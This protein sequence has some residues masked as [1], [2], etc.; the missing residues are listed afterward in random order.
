[1]FSAIYES[2]GGITIMCTWTSNTINSIYTK[3]TKCNNCVVK[4]IV[5]GRLLQ[6]KTSGMKNLSEEITIDFANLTIEKGINKLNNVKGIFGFNGS[7]KTA[8]M[9]SVD[10]Y[11]RIATDPTFLVQKD[12]TKKLDQL[13]N[14]ETRRFSFSIVFEFQKDTVLKHSIE[15]AKNQLSGNFYIQKENIAFS[16][17][18]TLNDS[19][20]SL[21]KKEVDSIA[22]LSYEEIVK[23]SLSFLK[24]TDLTYSSILP[25]V[26]EKMIE[27][28]E[29]NGKHPHTFAEKVF[30]NLFFSVKN[31][32]VYLSAS[33]EHNGFL[34]DKDALKSLLSDLESQ[35]EQRD[36]WADLY[37]TETIIP[38]N[39]YDAYVEN[40]RKLEK[41][42]RLFKPELQEIE[43]ERSEDKDAYHVKRLFKYE[44]YKVEY[45]FESSGIKQLVKLFT[46]LSRCANGGVVFIDEIDVNINAV[47]FEKLISFFRKYGEGQ[48]IFTTHNT[49]AM[50]ALKGQSRSI[51]VLGDENK[52]DVW[53]GKGNKSP[54]NDYFGGLFPHSPMNIE[55]FDFVNIFLGEE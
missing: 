30:S 33:D 55:D 34:F 20:K 11:L 50:N 41:F 32:D 22:V 51:L 36:D 53:V 37:S 15:L 31:M 9:T 40:N 27:R 49:E 28:G 52:M 5:M 3:N 44:K 42:V 43:L 2:E 26:I 4:G 7:G 16:C 29:R 18:R 13:L 14:F 38:K 10:Y 54:I 25:K 35:K 39:M 45:E 1:M 21:V 48:L 46:Y 19:F 24:S 12:T 47:Y 8:L 17:G 6:I 23:D